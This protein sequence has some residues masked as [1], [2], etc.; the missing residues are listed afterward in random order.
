MNYR[1]TLD[2]LYHALPVYQHIGGAAYKADL[3]NARKLENY[4]GT[5]HKRFR[6]IHIG[7]TNGKGSVSIT[8][9]ESSSGMYELVIR[10]NGVGLPEDLNINTINSLGL[11][12][13]K[14]LVEEQLNGSLELN[15]HQGTAWCIRFQE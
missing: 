13:V 5:S 12:L 8:L 6:S 14:G 2:Y 1:E 3:I 9:S 10:D 4:F 7:G 15:R 11:Q